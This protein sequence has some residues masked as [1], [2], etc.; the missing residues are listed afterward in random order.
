MMRVR[1]LRHKRRLRTRIE[2]AVR[3]AQRELG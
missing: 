3:V 2:V 1:N